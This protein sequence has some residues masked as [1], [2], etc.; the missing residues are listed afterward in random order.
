MDE[1]QIEPVRPHLPELEVPL[2]EAPERSVLQP[3]NLALWQAYM[4]LRTVR[5]ADRDCAE[6]LRR[7][8]RLRETRTTWLDREEMALR[9][10]IDEA[11]GLWPNAKLTGEPRQQWLEHGCLSASG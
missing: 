1:K 2:F 3:S 10:A 8:R 11:L 9:R 7:L 5:M 6:Q 4:A